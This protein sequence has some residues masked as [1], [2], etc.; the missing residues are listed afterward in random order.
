MMLSG[1]SMDY[2]LEMPGKI[3]DG[4]ADTIKDNK[5]EWHLVGADISKTKIYAK[6][7]IPILPF[8]SGS[9]MTLAF[10]GIMG[11][12]FIVRKRE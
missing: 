12:L 1:I 5:A 8:L 9:E 11:A 6:S 3:V 2:Y 4:N 10:L 7:D